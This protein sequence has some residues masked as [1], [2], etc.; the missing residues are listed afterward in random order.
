MRRR[1]AVA[2]VLAIMFLAAAPPAAQPGED[3]INLRFDRVLAELELSEEQ[4]ARVLALRQQ[5]EADMRAL[6]EAL[7]R[8]AVE[9]RERVEETP[10]EPRAIEDLVQEIGRVQTEMLRARVRAI[11]D[12]RDVLPPKQQ[13]RL[14]ALEE[15]LRGA[16]G[17]APGPGK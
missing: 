13:H 1:R 9:L 14:K 8:K 7:R 17:P 2:G 15:I 6:A 4:R 3:R 11:R 12:L 10:G 5:F 16:R